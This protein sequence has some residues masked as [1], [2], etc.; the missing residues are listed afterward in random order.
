MK[1][2]QSPAS[3]KNYKGRKK[4]AKSAAWHE[5]MPV[6]RE[7]SLNHLTLAEMS[8]QTR[9]PFAT[10]SRWINEDE[11]L[12]SLYAELPKTMVSIVRAEAFKGMANALPRL[13]TMS[14]STN[15]SVALRSTNQLNVIFE[16]AAR[17]EREEQAVALLEERMAAIQ[18]LQ[19][20]G[21]HSLPEGILEPVDVVV[22]PAD[23]AESLPD[24]SDEMEI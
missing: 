22:A 10:L 21:N 8:S 19:V 20:V 17:Y 18:E 2:G 1:A 3:T 12:K 6:I 7:M 24:Q 11:E 16:T 5:F 23:F 13:A 4:G 15:A 9:V 14:K